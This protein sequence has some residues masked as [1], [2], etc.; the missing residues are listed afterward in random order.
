MNSV[1]C[2]GVGAWMRADKGSG[3][4]VGVGLVMAA[5]MLLST[6]LAVG[7][8]LYCRSVAQTAADHAAL[9]AATAL[10][11]SS[12]D[13]CA[14]GGSTAAANRARLTGCAI[15]GEDVTVTAAVPTRVP[16]VVDASA[17]ARAGPKDCG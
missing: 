14:E 16:F 17:R 10:Y 9:A 8:V 4:V 12:G 7:N 15:T 2:G 13:P 6:I 5:A 11:E 1:G 3:T